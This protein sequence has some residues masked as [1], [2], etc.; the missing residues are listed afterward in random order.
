MLQAHHYVPHSNVGQALLEGRHL[1]LP[2]GC[3]PERATDVLRL[4]LR[5]TPEPGGDAGA[6]AR[7]T[8]QD[9]IGVRSSL[10]P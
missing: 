1:H 4:D 3:Y 8:N 9:Q 7:R 5:I 10:A 2:D 6:F